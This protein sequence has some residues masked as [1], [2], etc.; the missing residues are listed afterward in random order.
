[1]TKASALVSGRPLGLVTLRAGCQ[2]PVVAGKS[3]DSVEPPIT[4]AEAVT[5]S[6]VARSNRRPPS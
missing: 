3:S 2:A 1:M 4:T 5:E 6:V